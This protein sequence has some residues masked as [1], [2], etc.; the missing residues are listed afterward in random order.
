MSKQIRD[1]MSMNTICFRVE[2][3]L[4]VYN[5]ATIAYKWIRIYINWWNYI[6]RKLSDSHVWYWAELNYNV[7]D[8]NGSERTHLEYLQ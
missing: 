7:Y 4:I 3:E 6:G 1:I 8:Y 2:V 5:M